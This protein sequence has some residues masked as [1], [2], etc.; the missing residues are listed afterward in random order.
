MN[1]HLNQCLIP[2]I[3]IRSSASNSYFLN[4]LIML[5]QY[6]TISSRLTYMQELISRKATG[7][8]PEFA[9]RLGISESNLALYLTY[10]RNHGA[11]IRYDYVSDSYYYDDDNEIT[12]DCGFKRK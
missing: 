7:S 3:K 1:T 10:F 9:A 6:E 4:Y 12:Y 11:K 5:K 2:K 8:R